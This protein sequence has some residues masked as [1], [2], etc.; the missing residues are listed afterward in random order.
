MDEELE[1][2]VNITP[3][4]DVLESLGI[5]LADFEAAVAAMQKELAAVQE[6][7]VAANDAVTA[8]QEL[9]RLQAAQDEK[10]SEIPRRLQA[11]FETLERMKP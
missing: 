8:R 3:R 1:I 10:L 5:S 7:A 9:L 11:Q 2:H 6:R 4:D